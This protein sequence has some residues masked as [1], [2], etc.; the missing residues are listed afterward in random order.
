MSVKYTGNAPAAHPRFLSD[1]PALSLTKEEIQALES[2]DPVAVPD[3]GRKYDVGNHEIKL[4][5]IQQKTGEALR[6][7][8]RYGWSRQMKVIDAAY[9]KAL[10]S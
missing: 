6:I 3:L 7:P 5:Y 2:G 10:E 8:V 9:L 1:T 4:A